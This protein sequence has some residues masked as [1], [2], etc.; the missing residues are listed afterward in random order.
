VA[1]DVE[2]LLVSILKAL[3]RKGGWSIPWEDGCS[4]RFSTARWRPV[5]APW[6]SSSVEFAYQQASKI[7]QI[8]KQKSRA[9]ARALVIRGVYQA[10][11]F[12]LLSTLVS[13]LAAT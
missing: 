12:F 4:G 8:D 13:T 10:L 9:C 6:T 11:D 3:N 5:S 2:L 1:D 7:K